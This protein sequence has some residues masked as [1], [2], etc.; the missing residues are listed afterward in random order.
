MRSLPGP[1]AEPRESFGHGLPPVV[2]EVIEAGERAL[3]AVRRRTVDHWIKAGAAWKALQLQAMFRS[4]SNAPAG[5]RYAAVYA[6]LVHPWPELTK[7]D[8]TTRKDAIW[9]FENDDRVLP[10][11]AALS[12][13]ERDRWTHPSTVRR[14]YERRHP[15]VRVGKPH[16]PRPPRQVRQRE[17]RPLG[18][19]TP[20]DL[21]A[22]IAELEEALA[23]RDRELIEKDALLEE[24]DRLIAQQRNDLAWLQA[25][26]R[27]YQRIV[28]PP[29][30]AEVVRESREVV[31]PVR[32][33]KPHYAGWARLMAAKIAAATTAEE[34]E[35]LRADNRE[36]IAAFEA[37]TPGGGKGVEQR[38]DARLS[39]V[40][41]K[42]ASLF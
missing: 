38:I 6:M 18:E 11:L 36:H 5:R 9:L 3:V 29:F 25:E 40:T 22:I 4:R 21:E 10:W 31:P 42:P 41:E 32:F 14:H 15:E 33:D 12:T 27:Q 20:E 39:E 8:R 13:K 7:V 17:A 26:V 34:L 35:Q 2:G 23:D 28:T 24:R 16:K 30:A 37:E 1:D 19:R